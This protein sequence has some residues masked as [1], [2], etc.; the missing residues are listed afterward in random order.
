MN[1]LLQQVQDAHGPSACTVAG[2]RVRRIEGEATN[3]QLHDGQTHTPNFGSHGVRAALDSFG[4]HVGG[5]A[6]KGVCDGVDG[7]GCNT[8]VAELDV[9]P[10]VDEDVGGFDI[11]MHDPVGF[12]EIDQ[13]TQNRFGDFAQ[14]IDADGA[15]VL[16]NA[17]KRAV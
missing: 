1:D 12:V 7:L 9:A 3:G 2:G 5:G 17:I 16:G 13:A 11:A 14:H 6:D 15:K 8:K 10:R 4:G